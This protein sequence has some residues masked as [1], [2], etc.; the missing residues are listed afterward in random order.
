MGGRGKV[1]QAEGVVVRSFWCG[2]MWWVKP[3]GIFSK[4][5]QALK[6][7]IPGVS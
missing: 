4:L 1:L 6:R 5:S 3:D 7:Q 2:A